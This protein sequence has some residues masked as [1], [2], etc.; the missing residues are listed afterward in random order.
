MPNE[1]GSS[2]APQ[3]VFTLHRPL[4]AQA[5]AFAPVIFVSEAAA[6]PAH[7]R[8]FQLLQRRDHVVAITRVCSESEE[9]SPTQMPS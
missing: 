3:C 9:S 7:D 6:G 1:L 2:T 4:V 8:H 5:D